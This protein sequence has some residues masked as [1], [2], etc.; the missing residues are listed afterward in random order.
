MN[1]TAPELYDGSIINEFT[2]YRIGY[3]HLYTAPHER[4]Y[5]EMLHLV[6][7]DITSPKR[8][9]RVARICEDFGIR[10]EYSVFECDLSE[11]TFQELW[12]RLAAT[13]D[14]AEDCLLAYKICNSCTRKVESMGT[15][16]RP[17]KVLLYI[18]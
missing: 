8:L 12:T 1:A 2:R 15:V 3:T 6:A 9:R 11:E 5:R 7:Y 4:K 10:V 17:G 16:V 18:P 14:A 13:I